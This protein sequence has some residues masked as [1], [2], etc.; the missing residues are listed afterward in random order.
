[1][2]RLGVKT[3]LT[4]PNLLHLLPLLALGLAVP[5]PQLFEKAVAGVEDDAGVAADGALVAAEGL[6]RRPGYLLVLGV[7]L[8]GEVAEELR[9]RD[10]G[11]AHVGAD[12]AA[13]LVAGLE[14]FYFVFFFAWVVRVWG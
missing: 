7:V 10:F 5:Q 6:Q 11:F 2:L 13:E 14:D 1:M 8:A 4:I 12:L 3:T 9:L